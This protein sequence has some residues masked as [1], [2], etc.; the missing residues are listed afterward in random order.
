MTLKMID[1]DNLRNAVIYFVNTSQPTSASSDTPATVGD[2]KT[3][4]TK[5]AELFNTF[6]DELE[7]K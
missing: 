5:T 4:I 1:T 3:V 2:I 6:I 7:Q